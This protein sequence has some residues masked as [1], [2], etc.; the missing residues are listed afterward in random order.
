[1]NS[2]TIISAAFKSNDDGNYSAVLFINKDINQL[3]V[4]FYTLFC[5]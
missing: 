3:R 5:I 1:M 4:G 2:A